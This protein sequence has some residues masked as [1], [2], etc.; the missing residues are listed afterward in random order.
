MTTFPAPVTRRERIVT[1]ADVSAAIEDGMTVGVGGFINTGHPMALVRQLII[2]GK[3]DLTVVGA[4]SAGL[5][6][7]MLIAAGCVSKVVT[8]YVGA[9]GFAG[10]G[11]AFRKAAQDASIE[12]FELDEAHYYAGLRASAQGVPFNPWRAGVGTSFAE[13]NPELKEFRDPVNDELL[14]AVPAINIDVCLLH[15]AISDVY[16][17]VQHNGTRYGDVAM[18]AASAQTFVSVERVVSPEFIRANPRETSIAGA[19]AIVRAA[20]GAHPFSAD[21]Y[22]VPDAEHIK[23]Y[24]AVADEWLRTGDRGALDGYF[25]EFIVDTADHVGYLTKIGLD[26]LLS[27]YEF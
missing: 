3:R 7:D 8:P 20:F 17:N 12:I 2:E 18:S 1:V 9:E 19:T 26:R 11:P 13:I 27:L 21:G 15:A 6:V 24:L 10:I 22:Y 16:G 25:K 5:E 14:L 23:N 4:A